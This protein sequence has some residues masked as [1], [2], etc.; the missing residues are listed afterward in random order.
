MEE[1]REEGDGGGRYPNRPLRP[2]H[3][4]TCIGGIHVTPTRRVLV[5][6]C[7]SVHCRFLGS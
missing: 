7:P 6:G 3:A 2:L 4:K 5:V 1:E